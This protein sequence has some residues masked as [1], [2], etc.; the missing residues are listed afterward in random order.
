MLRAKVSQSLFFPICEIQPWQRDSV[1][2][3]SS[4]LRRNGVSQFPRELYFTYNSMLSGAHGGIEIG[5]YVKGTTMCGFLCGGFTSHLAELR[6]G[7]ESVVAA[8]YFILWIK[9]A[10]ICVTNLKKKK[11]LCISHERQFTGKQ[12]RGIKLKSTEEQE[13]IRAVIPRPIARACRRM[14]K[15]DRAL[16]CRAP[17]RTAIRK[18]HSSD[19]Q[20]R[21]F[22]N[23][24]SLGT[25]A[26]TRGE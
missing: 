13:P 16:P 5:P 21:G 22:D 26:V 6:I 3:I 20:S 25:K 1:T 14:R 23:G 24:Y 2:T 19:K 7:A 15:P 17:R 12:G 9:A 10:Q 4:N 18:N 11:V 8:R